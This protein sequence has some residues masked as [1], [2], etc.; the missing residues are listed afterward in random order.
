[1]DGYE[2]R[3]ALTESDLDTWV[4]FPRREVYDSR[5]PWVAPLDRDLRRMLDRRKNPFFRHGEAEP[6][7][8]FD[9]HGVVAG[10]IL[11]HIYHRHTVRHGERAAFFGYFE[12]RDDVDAAQTLIEGAR[13]FG[14][15]FGCTV[16]RGPFNMTA[17]QEMGVLVDGFDAPPAVDETY[18]APYYPA[19]L[20]AAGLRATFSVTT[21]R[22]DDV[23]QVDP[24]SLLNERHRALTTAGRLH[25]RP[26]DPKQY[27]REFEI[28][29]ELLN[30]SFGHNR[31]F[32]PITDEEFEFQL[33]PYRRLIDPAISLVAEL[34]GVPC[35]FIVAVPDYNL[36]L[37]HMGGRMGPRE[38]LTFLRG[39]S[40]IHDACLI[41]MGVQQQLQ[42]RGV[43]RLMQAELIRALRRSGYRSLTVTWIADENAKSLGTM[44]ALGARPLHRLTLYETEL[45]RHGNGQVD[46]PEWL[47]G[48]RLAP[49]AHNTQPWRFR[50]L[51]GGTIEVRWDPQRTL[52][53][54]DPTNRDLFLSLGATVEAARLRSTA[55]GRPL[56]FVPS[57]SGSQLSIG[58][59]VPD[60]NE[61]SPDD[62]R[63]A[64]SLA[65]RHTARVS[66]AKTTVSPDVIA[67]LTAEAARY[68]CD[69]SVVTDRRSVK[70]LAALARRATAALYADS[71]VHEELWRWLRLEPADPAYRRDGLTAD[72][73]DLH[74]IA[75]RGARLVLP[76]THMRRLVPLGFHHLLALDTQRVVRASASLCLLTASSSERTTIVHAGQC[77]MR[78][79]LAA[80][81]A[82][83]S[84]HPISALLDCADTVQ[85]TLD[86]FNRR[87][88]I[89][90]SIFRLGA[91]P[92]VPRAPRLEPSELLEP[93]P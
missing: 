21:F 28:L 38:I 2:I 61:P 36:V 70:R 27:D 40:R 41:I 18:T 81:V 24:D 34:D 54:G 48:A 68:G 82:G 78:L 77:L 32:V 47:E 89:P 72:T 57:Q 16:V 64:Q 25:I 22:I 51:S 76:P 88:A 46:V 30:D 39:K 79:W 33:G 29:R 85:P 84:T 49:S 20:E 43:M 23:A 5:S 13:A 37:R 45:D 62:L 71:I 6:L 15:R 86:V 90:A 91:C 58:R 60:G 66:H 44:R 17:M 87:G 92:P 65:T 69:L 67:A 31:Y 53:A 8:A 59:L 35:G 19:L 74:G 9:R 56:A 55:A 10:R 83:L 50:P 80:D 7:L 1:M 93:A 11:T 52:P 4:Q 26:A 3:P 63:L 42:G 73:L 75:L 14:R 12:C